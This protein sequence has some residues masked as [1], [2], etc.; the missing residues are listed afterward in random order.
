MADWVDLTR[1]AALASHRLIGWIYWD[2]RAI[3]NYAA[4][5][6]PNGMGYYIASRAAS[7]APAGNSAVGAA[8]GSIHPGFVKA[9]LDLCRTHTNGALSRTDR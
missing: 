8:F 7:L 4:L 6:V 3:A 1:R 2:P 9:S 5:G